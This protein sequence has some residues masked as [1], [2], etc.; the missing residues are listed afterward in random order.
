MVTGDHIE[1]AK[2]VALKAGIIRQE[3]LQ[4]DGIAMTGDKFMQSIGEFERKWDPTHKEYKIKFMEERRFHDVK[5]R[6]KII[7]RATAEHKFILIS[8]IK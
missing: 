1:T 6:L 2:A 5:K 3:E 4:L 7:A 8:G